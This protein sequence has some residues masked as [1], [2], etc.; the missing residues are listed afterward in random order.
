M[1]DLDFP[2]LTADFDVIS[3]FAA[4]TGTRD[5]RNLH[6]QPVI[7]QWLMAIMS[8]D[9]TVSLLRVAILQLVNVVRCGGALLPLEN[10]TEATIPLVDSHRALSLFGARD[11]HL[12]TIRETLGVSITHRDGEIR[13]SGDEAAVARATAALSQLSSRLDQQVEIGVDHVAD[14]LAQVTG[15]RL[16]PAQTPVDVIHAARR[17][18]PRTQGQARYIQSIR[19]HDITF[20]VGPA[21]TGKTYL[22]VAVAVEALKHH[23]TR[24]IVLVRP[25]VEAGESLG[26]LPGDLQ[27]KINPYLRPLLDA[28]I[29]MIDYDQMKRYMEQDVIEVIPLA[30]MRGRTLNESFIILD[31]AQNTTIAQMKMFLTRMGQG[32]KIVISGDTTQIDLP[33]PS[34]SGLIDALGRLRDIPGVNIVQLHKSDIVRHRLVQEIVRAYEEDTK[35]AIPRRSR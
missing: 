7:H 26:F 31:E 27:A 16:V 20:A 15:K 19:E 23:Q 10:M 24:K 1:S 2:I 14:V 33:R 28:L 11:Q 13:V 17:V 34:A 6:S 21:G 25:A 9:A 22:A 12:R 29:E 4:I 32:S 5:Q 18:T 3:R 35:A 30:Y 8:A